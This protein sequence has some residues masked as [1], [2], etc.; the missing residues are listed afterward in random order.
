MLDELYAAL[1]AAA[2]DD[3]TGSFAPVSRFERASLIS[4]LSGL[5]FPA[6]RMAKWLDIMPREPVTIFFNV[7]LSYTAQVEVMPLDE[8]LE[9]LS[10][11]H[12]DDMNTVKTDRFWPIGRNTNNDYLLGIQVACTSY[13]SD[14]ADKAVW[15]HDN[16]DDPINNIFLH[17]QDLVGDVTMEAMVGSL[18]ERNIRGV[19]NH[20]TSNCRFDKQWL[21]SIV[22]FV[23][24]YRLRSEEHISFLGGNSIGVHKLLWTKADEAHWWDL[25]EIEDF[26]DV[27]KAFQNLPS[28]NKDFA[29]T[30]NVTNMSFPYVVHR[31]LNGSEFSDRE[32]EE[33]IMAAMC[34]MHYQFLSSLFRSPRFKY[35]AD[36]AVSNAAFNSL[37]NK[38]LLKRCGS[39]Q[40]LIEVRTHQLVDETS[41]HRKAFEE[42]YD[43]KALLY[44]IMD[45]QTSIRKVVNRLTSAYYSAHEADQ[46]MMTVA[47]T[48]TD[49]EGEEVLRE[50]E[51]RADQ[52]TMNTLAMTMDPYA[53][54]DNSVIAQTIKL[55]P[56]A[57]ARYLKESLLELVRLRRKRDP[58]AEAMIRELIMFIME[59]QR[60][61]SAE[62]RTFVHAVIKIAN[63]MRSSQATDQYALSIKDKAGDI[64]ATVLGRRPANVQSACR[65]ALVVYLA[66]RLLTYRP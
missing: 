50:I 11:L 19:F 41:K 44:I 9:A 7:D 38:S 21:R 30:G 14:T 1:R 40:G 23:R 39:W 57:D 13:E 55:V 64:V 43:D 26:S 47:A 31:I 18:D 3:T 33:G 54:I 35:G 29:V 49:S 6:K 59:Q 20:F 52:L 60:L 36:E 58:N 5:G 37:T 51:S 10:D 53:T 61:A 28:V 27:K 62:E 42:C 22:T 32:R 45:T 12:T 66:L 25:L 56:T 16:L 2:E 4:T 34:L 63:M 24:Q 65:I 17:K 46:R 15:R 8:L 48:F